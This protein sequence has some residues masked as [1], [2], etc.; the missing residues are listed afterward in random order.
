MGCEY[1]RC[2]QDDPGWA[3]EDRLRSLQALIDVDLSLLDGDGLLDELLDRLRITVNA[4]T[5]VV[6]LLDSNAR[7]LVIWAAR[8]ID[9][10]IDLNLRIPVGRGL[11]GRVAELRRPQFLNGPASTTVAIPVLLEKGI[12]SMLGVPL[13][14]AGQLTGVLHVGRMADQPFADND[15]ELLQVVAERIAGAVQARELAVERATANLLERSLQL[16]RMPNCPGFDFAARYRTPEDRTVGGDWYDLFT[17]PDGELWIVTGDVA[18][19]GLNAAVVAGRVRSSLRSYALEG[20]SPADVLERTD[21]KIQH[22]EMGTMITLVCAVSRPPHDELE[23]ALAGHPPPVLIFPGHHA[24]LLEA[25]EPG[26]P[27][28]TLPDIARSYTNVPFPVGSLLFM[29]TDGL[30]ERRDSSIDAGLDRLLGAV[31]IGPVADVCD[32]I[33]HSL[34]EG[35]TLQDDV[36]LVAVHRVP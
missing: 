4:D 32:E 6:L 22:F 20:G 19:H 23:I 2:V 34:L 26:P 13:L 14:V 31:H 12:R 35:R 16:E 29:Y 24:H 30:I 18:G 11:T 33:I 27:L 10:E 9:E 1:Y 8:G 36:A 21:R 7:E 5:A 3:A 17:L 25:E 28:G 15:A